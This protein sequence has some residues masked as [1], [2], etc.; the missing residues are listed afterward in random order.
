MDSTL[1]LFIAISSFIFTLYQWLVHMNSRRP[2]MRFL[3]LQMH[4]LQFN[5][6]YKDFRIFF[7]PEFIIV[8]LS[9]LPDAL[10]DM[11]VYLQIA[12]KW[13]EGTCNLPLAQKF[14]IFLP[15]HACDKFKENWFFFSFP[16]YPSKEELKKAKLYVEFSDQYDKTYCLKFDSKVV[17]KTKISELPEFE[18]HEH[19]LA[20]FRTPYIKHLIY[21]TKGEQ[22]IGIYDY[23]RYT[24]SRSGTY[25]T[26]QTFKIKAM[27][28][29]DARVL[30]DSYT[31]AKLYIVKENG[32]PNAIEI[33]EEGSALRKIDI[34]PAF[35]AEIQKL[36]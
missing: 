27:D 36:A 22:H 31:A 32:I 7:D 10:M 16:V 25:F 17:A 12:G 30:L 23:D 24:R 19:D 28:S 9:E 34:P 29:P 11:K 2:Q 1:A 26:A 33:E 18:E 14:P 21:N 15:G 20:T 35:I 3:R 8:N 13:H 4:A 5:H 6:D